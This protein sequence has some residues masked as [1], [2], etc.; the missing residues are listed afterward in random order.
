MIALVVCSCASAEQPRA[1]LPGADNS[2]L[3]YAGEIWISQIGHNLQAS[4]A[5]SGVSSIPGDNNDIPGAWAVRVRL[6]PRPSSAASSTGR[7]HTLDANS[8][9][10]RSPAG[11]HLLLD[12]A[13]SLHGDLPQDQALSASR[14][15]NSTHP[16]SG[17]VKKS[18]TRKSTKA[19]A[20]KGR[21]QQASTTLQIRQTC[22]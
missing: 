22:F 5:S 4:S 14:G 20:S 10:R 2:N 13:S 15:R 3:R 11:G 9:R 17:K 12:E 16:Q 1:I 6:Q 8:G 21:H 19:S 18:G 7:P